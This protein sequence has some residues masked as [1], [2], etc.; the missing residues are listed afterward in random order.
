MPFHCVFRKSAAAGRALPHRATA[1]LISFATALVICAIGLLSINL[2]TTNRA[3]AD[4]VDIDYQHLIGQLV[5]DQA[6]SVDMIHIPYSIIFVQRVTPDEIRK[7]TNY[8]CHVDI[9]PDLSKSLLAAVKDAHAMWIDGNWDLRWMLRI[10]MKGN[11]APT[12]LYLNGR[13]F[14]GADQR[15]YLND[16]PIALTSS[17]SRWMV[18]TV[19]EVCGDLPI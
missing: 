12:T 9:T 1:R 14:V 3:Q 19:N 2:G 5:N 17:L 16:Q 15:G 6:V 7:W 10:N 4:Q 11:A 18:R 8:S 13:S